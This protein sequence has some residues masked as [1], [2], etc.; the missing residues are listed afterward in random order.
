M[1]SIERLDPITEAAAFE[2]ESL[3]NRWLASGRPLE[4][5][6][7]CLLTAAIDMSVDGAGA[8]GTAKLLRDMAQA[9][10]D[11]DMGEVITMAKPN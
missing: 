6:C 3:V 11:G 10:D 1:N 7:D 5:L 4:T 2:I 9:V 8:A